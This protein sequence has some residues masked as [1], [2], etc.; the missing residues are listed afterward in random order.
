MGLNRFDGVRMRHYKSADYKL[1]SDYIFSM[2]ED[3]EG[4]IW[5]G[6]SRGIACYDYSSDSFFIPLLQDGTRVEDIVSSIAV[7]SKGEVWFSLNKEEILYKY[8]YSK[9]YLDTCVV[10]IGKG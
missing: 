4:N 10:K 7:N 6:T 5:F 1:P 8:D 2:V 3:K 9:G